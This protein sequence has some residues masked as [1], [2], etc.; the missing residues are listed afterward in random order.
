VK[1]K[2]P[3]PD[4]SGVS[5]KLTAL[6]SIGN[7]LPDADGTSGSVDEPSSLLHFRNEVL[8]EQSLGALVEWGVLISASL[9]QA[10]E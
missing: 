10:W 5:V 3:T 9:L 1:L 8:V 6:E 4:I 2:E 7:I